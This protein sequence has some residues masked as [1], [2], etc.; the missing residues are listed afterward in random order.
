[1]DIKG[2]KELQPP[3]CKEDTK[4]P[5]MVNI[6]QGWDDETWECPVC[7]ARFKL[8]YEDMK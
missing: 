2:N 8:Y 3:E 7:G 6:Y 1:M 4:C 5:N